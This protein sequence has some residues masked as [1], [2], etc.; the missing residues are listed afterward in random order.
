L[1]QASQPGRLTQSQ[2]AIYYDPKTDGDRADA[3]T[4]RSFA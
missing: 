1:K 3:T 4:I 2:L